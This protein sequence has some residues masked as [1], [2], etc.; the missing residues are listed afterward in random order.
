[1]GALTYK[2][3]GSLE[4]QL[5]FDRIDPEFLKTVAENMAAIGDIRHRLVAESMGIIAG[6]EFHSLFKP[7]NVL[8]VL[9]ALLSEG[10]TNIAMNAADCVGL[11]G[12]PEEI[13]RIRTT[14]V[15]FNK[16]GTKF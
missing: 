13:G 14:L 10:H 11:V 3:P 4:G 7:W 6:E 16:M 2:K 12:V 8:E 1:M 5:I 9:T 15:K